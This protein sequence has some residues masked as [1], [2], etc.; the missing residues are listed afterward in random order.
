MPFCSQCGLK[1]DISIGSTCSNGHPYT[2]ADD[3]A[4]RASAQE[5]EQEFTATCLH[6]K[7]NYALWEAHGLFLQAAHCCENGDYDACAAVCRAALES[8]LSKLRIIKPTPNKIYMIDSTVLDLLPEIRFQYNLLV[9]WA[10]K[11]EALSKSLVNK[12]SKVRELGNFAVHLSEIKHREIAQHLKEVIETE[13]PTYH[14]QMRP[15]R[16]W[17]APEE[18]YW[19]LDVTRKAILQLAEWFEAQEP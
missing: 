18:A 8:A 13:S 1:I 7:T 19:G 10:V 15:Y 12:M 2:L 17:V 6:L 14:H 4:V 3:Q 16:L 5:L 9:R 11:N